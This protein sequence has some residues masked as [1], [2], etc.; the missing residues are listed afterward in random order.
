MSKEDFTVM[1]VLVGL[2]VCLGFIVGFI[3]RGVLV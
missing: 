2:A 3:A 1:K